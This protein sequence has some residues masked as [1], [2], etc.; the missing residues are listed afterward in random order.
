MTEV[1]DV[2]P[3]N[4]HSFLLALEAKGRNA[5]ARDAAIIRLIY[6]C[7]LRR[8]ELV[9]LDLGLTMTMKAGGL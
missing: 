3:N 8:K 7:G 2:M 1:L 4:V 9:T 5:G 6:S